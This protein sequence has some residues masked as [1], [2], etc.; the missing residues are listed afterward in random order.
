MAD[1]GRLNGPAAGPPSARRRPAAV[2]ALLALALV[3]APLPSRVAGAEGGPEVTGD[4]AEI[5]AVGGGAVL[6][7]SAVA[8]F[9]PDASGS[10]ARLSGADRFA[11]SAA[12][13]RHAHPDGAETVYLATG[14]DFPDALSAATAVAAHSAA[15]LL[16]AGED[17]PAP[18]ATELQRLDPRRIFLLGGTSAVGQAVHDRV[19]ALTGITPQRLAGTDRY[20]TSAA[21]SRHAHPDGAETVYLATG[22]DF[23]D[24]L[25]AATAVAAATADL[26]L[27][28][29]L[30]RPALGRATATARQRSGNVS[31]AAIGTDGVLIGHH[32]ERAVPAASVLKVM[33]LVA[34]LRG[35]SVRDRALTAQD[36][37]LLEPMITRSAN[38][39]ASAIANQ[40][41]PGAMTELAAAAGMRDFSYTRPWGLSRTSAR[42]QVGLMLALPR[43]LP[44]RHRDYA[45]DLL[46]RVVPEQRWALGAIDTGRW[47]RHF[48]GGWG[49][50]SGAVT[51]EVA[52][53]RHPDGSTVAAAVMIT[54]SP[55]HRYGTDTLRLVFAELLRGL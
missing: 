45:L 28:N 12:V 36:R 19:R 9:L 49:S 14:L 39:P 33:F 51:H 52:L 37:A 48:K 22:L 24:A 54:G 47:Q 23:P 34:Y 18:V 50:G 8:R 15:L 4:A 32:S 6:P 2:A 20:A 44:E 40:L 13:S 3:L 17:I 21:V 43:L 53:L 30:W 46:T 29:P 42:D 5:V 41:G 16:V 11:T 10:D 26:A 35:P 25:A 31:I 55:S 38:E 7:D 1:G 27:V